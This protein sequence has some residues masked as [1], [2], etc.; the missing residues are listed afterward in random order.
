VPDITQPLIEYR[1]RCY[2]FVIVPLFGYFFAAWERSS[3]H[4]RSR[5]CSS[6][7]AAVLY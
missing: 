4:K 2:C 7:L 5:V 1:E 3:L 6:R